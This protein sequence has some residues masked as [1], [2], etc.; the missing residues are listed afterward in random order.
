MSFNRKMRREQARRGHQNPHGITRMKNQAKYQKSTLP[1]APPHKMEYC[2]KKTML[3]NSPLPQ[4]N[5][6]KTTL[7]P[8]ANI[9]DM[10]QARNYCLDYIHPNT[11]QDK[12][13]IIETGRGLFALNSVNEV[14]A[15]ILELEFYMANP[16][17]SCCGTYMDLSTFYEEMADIRT[18]FLS[19]EDEYFYVDV[20]SVEAALRAF[21]ECHAYLETD[22]SKPLSVGFHKDV[23]TIDGYSE[24]LSLMAR[25]LDY[26]ASRNVPV[27]VGA[28]VVTLQN[29][30]KEWG[31]DRIDTWN[32]LFYIW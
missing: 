5:Q 12:P 2:Y 1:P 16:R 13:L 29:K 4:S 14:C 25:I 11:K 9:F 28:L 18:A 32:H 24:V 6:Y 30:Q 22:Q 21:V 31:I 10:K 17:N 15:Q 8:T 23:E 26:L 7:E 20:R 3:R 27:H 19:N